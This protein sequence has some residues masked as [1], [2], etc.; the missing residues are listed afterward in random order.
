MRLSLEQLS[1]FSKGCGSAFQVKV[2]NSGGV[3]TLPVN[4]LTL[5]FMVL[6]NNKFWMSLILGC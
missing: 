5:C 1:E 2:E 3:V 4:R 6:Q